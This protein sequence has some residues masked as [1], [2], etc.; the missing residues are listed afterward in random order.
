MPVVDCLNF[1]LCVMMLLT[2]KVPLIVA[3]TSVWRC[4]G[5]TFAAFEVFLRV[6]MIYSATHHLPLIIGCSLGFVSRTFHHHIA[7]DSVALKKHE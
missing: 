6:E 5:L 1:N 4:W 7:P 2:Q 3:R